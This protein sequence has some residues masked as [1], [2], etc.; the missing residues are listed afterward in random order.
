[1][2]FSTTVLILS[3]L[4][5]SLVIVSVSTGVIQKNVSQS[6]LEIARRAASEISLY[7]RE[8][9]AQLRASAEVLTTLSQDAVVQNLLLENLSLNLGKYRNLYLVQENG[10]QIATSSLDK[11]SPPR[12]DPAL[13]REALEKNLYLSEVR[14]SSDNLPYLTV[15]VPVKVMGQGR[16]ILVAELNL[17][18]IWKLIDGI[19]IGKSGAAF[20]VSSRGVLIAHADKAKILRT[21]EGA[22]GAP[23]PTPLPREGTVILEN[24]RGNSPLLAAYCPVANTDWIVSIQ[25]PLR[26]AYLSA[27]IILSRTL[28][29]VLIGMALSAL[30]GIL[31][32]RSVSKPLEKLL[33]GTIL[34]AS[35]NLDHRIDIRTNDEMGRLSRSFNEMVDRLKD[36]SRELGESEQKYRLLAENVS[37]IIFAL[38]A[39]ARIEFF[40]RRVESL[41]G[42]DRGA[43]V[44]RS[45]PELISPEDRGA[46]ERAMQGLSA[47]NAPS[48]AELE[49]GIPSREGVRIAFEVRLVKF[50]DPAGTIRYYGVARDLTERRKLQ[51][52]LLQSEKLSSL[53]EIIAG[54]AHE[55]NNPLTSIVGFSE[56]M[57][58]KPDLDEEVRQEIESI[59]QEAER[60][61]R[62][63]KNLL[64]FARKYRPEKKPC[65]IGEIVE[66]VLELRSYEIK[67]SRIEVQNRIDA[68]LPLL[69]ADPNQLRQVFL[70]MINNAIQ[71]LQEVQGRRVLSMEAA[72]RG[73]GIEISFTDTGPGI[74]ADILPKIFD[75][76]FTTK[77]VGKGTGLGLSVSHGIITE[78]GGSIRV[79]SV[80]GEGTRF[81]I[82]LPLEQVP[83]AGPE[84]RG[85]KALSDLPRLRILAVDDEQPILSLI[86]RILSAQGSTVD[87]TDSG[88]KAL[89]YLKERDYDLVIS[90]LRMPGI[91]G[92]KLFQWIKEN[93]PH[94]AASLI[95]ITG[96][97][98]NPKVQSFLNEANVSYLKKPFSM[99]ELKK[100]VVNSL[101][102]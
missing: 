59:L 52:Q 20:L 37:D 3:I 50:Q 13:A 34:I 90:D 22:Q 100:A 95:F 17:R 92:W 88:E 73:D 2:I 40:N 98:L 82:R 48:A 99:E 7:F 54:V 25:Q 62:I 45:F 55:I 10:A 58:L 57:L 83:P 21:P 77:E 14:L 29:L 71:A 81:I 11:R 101:K 80:L 35:G 69:M 61:G 87:I 89:W 31:L 8:A 6:N 4:V 19:S 38:D 23:L 32:A 5:T 94:L 65:R 39:G 27:Q 93:R 18:D 91:D 15:A 41:T 44:G 46:F 67:V 66:S 51:Q 16:R 9:L 68:G 28:M 47:A 96:D 36:Q 75:P 78:H 56:L 42:L 102:S 24:A 70:N 49:V 64:T 97:I 74:R 86:Q 1:L 79:Q 12:L 76:F 72:A 26:E 43:L 85:E 84:G 30:V 63:V 60:T 33:E 53:G